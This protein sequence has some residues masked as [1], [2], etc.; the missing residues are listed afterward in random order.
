MVGIQSKAHGFNNITDLNL[1]C[2]NPVRIGIP[3]LF[4]IVRMVSIFCKKNNK[5]PYYIDKT[6]YL[7]YIIK[8]RYLINSQSWAIQKGC[9]SNDKDK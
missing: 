9:D 5:A 1:Q 2:G 6:A 8:V 7:R 4:L 3:A